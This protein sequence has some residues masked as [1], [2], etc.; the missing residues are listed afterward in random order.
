M[1]S[2]KLSRICNLVMGM[3]LEDGINMLERSDRLS[4]RSVRWLE[5]QRKQI[6]KAA[7]EL[8]MYDQ[9]IVFLLSRYPRVERKRPPIHPAGAVMY[10]EDVNYGVQRVETEKLK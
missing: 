6:D 10:P 5:S 2:R 3:A 1:A 7:R 9:R 8:K 4:Q